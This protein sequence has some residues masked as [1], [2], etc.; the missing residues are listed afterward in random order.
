MVRVVPSSYFRANVLT[1]RP[2]AAN[3]MSS[4]RLNKC[5]TFWYVLFL[6]I[7]YGFKSV[8]KMEKMYFRR[9]F[10]ELFRNWVNNIPLNSYRKC[11]T[12]SCWWFSL[13][14]SRFQVIPK[15]AGSFVLPLPRNRFFENAPH[16]ES[17]LLGACTWT[18]LCFSRD[19]FARR[20][21]STARSSPSHSREL[22]GWYTDGKLL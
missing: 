7:L 21:S 17:E 2:N 16:E 22:S 15:T 18:S 3:D 12:F 5:E 19:F 8:L 11:E 14:S 20:S 9:N 13:I 1:V 6:P 10:Y 4:E